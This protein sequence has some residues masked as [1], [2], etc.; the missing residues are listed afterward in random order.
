MIDGGW[1]GDMVDKKPIIDSSVCSSIK[2]PRMKES[3]E[4]IC[5]EPSGNLAVDYGGFIFGIS[6]WEG[7]KF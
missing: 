2:Y 5:L 6:T 3:I 4:I 7:I 1:R